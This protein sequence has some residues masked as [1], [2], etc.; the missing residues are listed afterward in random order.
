M[1]G[2]TVCRFHGGG[3][4]HVK[5]AGKRRVVVET[6]KVRAKEKALAYASRMIAAE[7]LENVDPA[8][9]LVETL[10]QWDALSNY[11]GEMC[12]AL[13]VASAEKIGQGLRGELK[14]SAP[15]DELDELAVGTNDHLLG[16]N[17]HG[18]AA[19]HPFVLEYKDALRERAKVAKMCLDAGIAERRVK[20]A[21]AQGKLIANVIRGLVAEIEKMLGQPIS[22]RPEFAPM[23]RRQLALVSGG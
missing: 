23:V 17:R 12:A 8:Q 21:E 4:P 18:E 1:L 11:W 10:L 19:I 5:A 13:D 2:L 3:A 9:K 22:S 16:F 15:T 14:Y 6:A 7:G 20:L